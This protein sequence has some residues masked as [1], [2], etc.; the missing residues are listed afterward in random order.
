MKNGYK[1]IS[2]EIEKT[3]VA[4]DS[5]NGYWVERKIDSTINEE[6]IIPATCPICTFMMCGAYDTETFIRYDCCERCYIQ[7]AESKTEQWKAGWRPDNDIVHQYIM[8]RKGKK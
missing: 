4:I 7:F 1:E 8:K 2:G 3:W 6:A 5:E